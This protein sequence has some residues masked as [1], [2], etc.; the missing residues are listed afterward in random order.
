MTRYMTRLANINISANC[1]SVKYL[2]KNKK[3]KKINV[4][5]ITKLS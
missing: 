5:I 1:L 3:V 4:S 2:F